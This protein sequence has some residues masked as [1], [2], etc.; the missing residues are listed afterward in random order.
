MQEEFI[1][2]YKPKIAKEL[3]IDKNNLIFKDIHRGSLGVSCVQVE[4]S[5][6]SDESILNLK[7]KYNIEKVDE[8]PLLET[9]QISSNI[10]DPEGNRTC[11]WG[12]NETRGGEAYI[13]PL[14]NWKGFGLKVT[15][16]YDKGNDD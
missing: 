4:S 10:L 6:A 3:N 11:G 1:K 16:L 2:N 13:P 15:G 14:N 5:E 12:Q 8:K 7:G 9:L